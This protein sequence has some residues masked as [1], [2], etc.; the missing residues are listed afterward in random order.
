MLALAARLPTLLGSPALV[1]SAF[2]APLVLVLAR[3]VPAEGVGLGIRLAVAAGCVLLLPGALLLRAIDWPEDLGVA[4]A[5][6]FVW[7]LAMLF[8]AL[9][10]TFAV[11]GSLSLVL[12][13]LVVFALA[14]LLPAAV[15]PRIELERAELLAV[16][17]VGLAGVAFAVVVWASGGPIVG[18]AL[19]HLARERKLVDLD[20]LSSLAALNEFRDGGVHPG[21][22]FPLWHAAVAL[23]SLLAGVDPA[24]T[25]RHGSAVLVPLSFVLVFAAARALFGSMWVA[26]AALVAQAAQFGLAAGHGGAY[27]SLVHPSAASRHLIV[28]ALLA[29]TFAFIHE[30]R[31]ALLPAITVGGL[32][33]ALAHP[34]YALFFCIVVA[35][36]LAVRALVAG[37]DVASATA[38]LAAVVIP[39]GA[40]AFWLLPVVR[41][42][43]SHEPSASELARGLARY[44]NQIDVSS[45]DSFRLAPELLARGGAVAVAALVLVPL[46]AL[47]PRRRWSAFVL[48][49]ALAVLLLTL[50]P[51]LFT[52]LADVVSLSQARR[53]AG[54]LPFA[55]A[56][57]GGL[58]V[59][60]RLLGP[61][62]L[63]VALAAGL[64][65]QWLYPGDFGYR[66]G[67]GAPALATWIAAFGGAA[68]L[69]LAMP[70]ARR[71]GLEREGPLVPAAAALFVL[72]V[73]VHGLSQIGPR[74]DVRA[75]LTP[76]L[77][78][79]LRTEVPEGDVVFSDAGTSYRIAAYAPV[80]VANALPAHV[81]D[82]TA[83]RPYERR[84]DASRFFRSGALAIPRRYGARWIVVDRAHFDLE[85]PL[86]IAYS[87]G[88]FVLYRMRPGARERRTR[89][90][91]VAVRG[92]SAR[93][94]RAP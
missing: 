6:A 54:F 31:A 80:Y 46:A 40:V 9:A 78:Q 59:L 84:R 19:F 56:F 86:P 33:L 41:E 83:N 42:T 81:A 25:A 50:A 35:G 69:A 93:P 91:T 24:E 43:V 68:G 18:D 57:A 61:L 39:A 65:L 74:L 60:A 15:A 58:T 29:L 77:V 44:G 62:L 67:D 49:A 5:G 70:F 82:T 22:A 48:G 34:S 51:P 66:L 37:R 64:V 79:A 23:V 32:A 30:R 8:A 72:P 73:A 90:G 36:F 85:L 52:R 1:G 12:V 17:A 10:V 20:G 94:G 14:A 28:P 55:F 76:G 92:E 4:V 2:A 38:S 13:L 89:L 87:D 21:Y 3:L 88:R 53:L 16:A 63:P 45:P 75:R 71:L 27:T 11:G 7:S 47:A 26:A